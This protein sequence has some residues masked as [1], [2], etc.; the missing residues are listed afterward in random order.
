MSL[1]TRIIA[2]AEA[3]GT[4]IKDLRTTRGTLSSL[5]TTAKTNLVA[6]INEQRLSFQEDGKAVEDPQQINR[7]AT[8]A[9]TKG[10]AWLSSHA[11]LAATSR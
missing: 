6:A 11:M 8:E 9:G 4:D 1:E 7:M 10:L 3:I 2:L 5:S